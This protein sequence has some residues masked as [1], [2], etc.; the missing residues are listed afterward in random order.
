MFGS[1]VAR[2][3]T[4][5][6]ID[7]WSI[8]DYRG[9]VSSQ[10][11]TGTG[12][13]SDFAAS[14]SDFFGGHSGSYGKQL[15]SLQDEVVNQLA[16]RAFRMGANWVIG[17][18]IDFDEISG[19]N[20]QMFMVSAQGTAV[21]ASP[22]AKASGSEKSALEGAVSGEEL[23]SAVERALLVRR[24][25]E[26][27]FQF[28]PET[29][30]SLCDHHVVDAI[31]P[32]LRHLASYEY[33]T[34]TLD[35]DR[36]GFVGLLR[37]VP[38][39]AAQ[40]ELH[41]AIVEYPACAA[42]AISMIQQYSLVD[43]TWVHEQLGNADFRLRHAALQLLKAQAPMYDGTSLVLM[44]DIVDSLANAFP[45]RAA[46]VDKKGFF[47]K[48]G[49][50]EWQCSFCNETNGLGQEYCRKCFRDRRGLKQEDVTPERATAT[51]QIQIECLE[52]ALRSNNR[53]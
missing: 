44:H 4:T 2:V 5:G 38:V 31:I 36:E 46:I 19:K 16:E 15:R 39:V 21:A 47:A 6:A 20:M 42:I 7:G 14:F 12:F 24:V 50:K 30:K 34:P 51:L 1:G 45:D 26:G 28:R 9:L 25:T 3:V 22:I 40:A 49:A 37:S 27:R 11:V 43:L 33:Q 53:E 32:G 13:F 23:V 48:E 10:I 52:R 41:R 18:R 8:T 17:T 29:W 35:A